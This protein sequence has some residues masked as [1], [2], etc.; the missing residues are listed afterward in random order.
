MAADAL[1]ALFGARLE[2]EYAS[3]GALLLAEGLSHIEVVA[4]FCVAFA[5]AMKERPRRRRGR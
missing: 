2:D 5:K 4:D 1:R 3:T